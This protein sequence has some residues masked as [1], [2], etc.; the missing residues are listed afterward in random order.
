MDYLYKELS[1]NAN[2]VIADVGAGT[3]LFTELLL[4]NASSVVAVEPNA[5]MRAEADERLSHFANYS[6]VSGSAENTGLDDKSIDVIVAAQAFHWFDLPK[7]K[8]EFTR[9]LRPGGNI[10]LIWNR[11]N[12]TGSEFLSKYETLLGSMIPEYSKVS[13]A[14]ASDKAIEGFFGSEMVMADFSNHQ[15]F[16]LQG[17]KGRLLSSSYCPKE[18]AEGH[19]E[20]MVAM[21]ELFYSYAIEDVVR[22][23]YRTQ[24]YHI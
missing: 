10:V 12:S 14:R 7:A 3:G 1:V 13:H 21:E 15:N 17:F 4:V 22:F 5:A 6:S 9:I 18:G 23:E 16:D 8:Q 19:F 11:R 24:V 20:L 2:S